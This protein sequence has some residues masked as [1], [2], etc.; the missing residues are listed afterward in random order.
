MMSGA[1]KKEAVSTVGGI[2][3]GGLVEGAVS[4]VGSGGV[5]VGVSVA[6]E[7]KKPHEEDERE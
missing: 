6:I 1:V 3:L 7:A 2:A 5:Q 4:S